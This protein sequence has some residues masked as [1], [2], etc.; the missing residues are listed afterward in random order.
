MKQ[1]VEKIVKLESE[2][3]AFQLLEGLN[4]TQ[5]VEVAKQLDIRSTGGKDEIKAAI[6]RGT[7]TAKNRSNSIRNY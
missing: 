7:V 2:V 5:L 6:I 1:V 4:R 3:E